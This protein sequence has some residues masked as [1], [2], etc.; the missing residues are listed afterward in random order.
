[1]AG[2]E[3]LIEFLTREG[4]AEVQH[5]SKI[6]FMAHL[7]GVHKVLVSWECSDTVCLG[8][9]FHSI[10][11]A[12]GFDEGALDLGHRLEIR[13]LIGTEAER[14]AFVNSSM[15][16]DSFDETL[17]AGPPHHVVNRF[18]GAP[19]ELTDQEFADLSRIQLADWLEQVER[20][21]GGWDYRRGVYRTVSERLGGP[22]LALYD[23]VFAREP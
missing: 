7:V 5:D 3:E 16:Y 21:P 1:M 20:T 2:Y 15:T 10:Y 19:I 13:A 18:T 23:E 12:E 9:L 8:G 17:R 22:A 11:G 6:E 4:T 14:L